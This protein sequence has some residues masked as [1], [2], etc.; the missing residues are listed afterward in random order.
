MKQKEPQLVIEYDRDWKRVLFVESGQIKEGATLDSIDGIHGKVAVVLLSRRISLYRSVALPDAQKA[1]AMI[2]LKQ[3][4]GD[5]FPIPAAELAFDFEPS[6]KVDGAGRHC[7]VFAAKTADVYAILEDCKKCQIDADRLIPVMAIAR[8]VAE[9]ENLS[10]GVIVEKFGDSITIDAFKD[11][12]PVGFRQSDLSNFSADLSRFRGLSG[13]RVL[14]YQVKVDGSEQV[15][16]APILSSTL[17]LPLRVDLEPEE[18]RIEKV[19][20]ERSKRHRQAYL[21]FAAGFCVSALAVNQ[22]IL[23]SD[24]RAKAEKKVANQI[25]QQTSAVTI[26]EDKLS[27][28]K[29]QE[30]QLKRAFTPA[31]KV[32]DIMKVA[33]MLVPKDAWLT[34]LNLERGKVLQIRGTAKN[35]EAIAAYLRELTKQKRFR[36][37]QLVFANATDVEDVPVVQFSISAFPVGNLPVIE[38]GK[39]RK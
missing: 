33:S 8:L 14:S 21:V 24:T 35:S 23:D 19:E 1:D 36:D 26:V 12:E 16:G 20:K 25:K 10:S 5:I 29:P 7:H 30:E 39:K 2:A 28:L 3:K 27:K 38:L 22:V 32:S 11:S 6:N 13:S 17:S 4:I 34:S 18:V 37:V 9:K 31:Q 15:L